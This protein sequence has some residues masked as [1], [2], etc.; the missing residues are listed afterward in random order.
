ML[1]R[2]SAVE[3]MEQ[4]AL[5]TAG[6]RQ[7]RR[8]EPDVLRAAAPPGAATRRAPIK[9]ATLTPAQVNA[10]IGAA[11][12]P[13]PI[14]PR[15]GGQRAA[16]DRRSRSCD[17]ADR[18]AAHRP[19]A[20]GPRAARPRRCWRS[21]IAEL[22]GPAGRALARAQDEYAQALGDF[23]DAAANHTAL[24]WLQAERN[25]TAEADAA[26]DRAISLDPRAAARR[27]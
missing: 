7:R 22:A 3:F 4:L 16:G 10:L 5:G 23:P 9:P 11:S 14:G 8:A 20:R 15:A 24:G 27:W 12:D 25:R 26:L 19:V 1:I 21:G 18:R 2:A 13:E 6:T 17:D